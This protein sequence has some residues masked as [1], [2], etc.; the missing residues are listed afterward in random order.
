MLFPL[1]EPPQGRASV[2]VYSTRV[3]GAL[4]ARK[5]EDS[6]MPF[7]V[8]DLVQLPC[9]GAQGS[10]ALGTQVLAAAQAQTLPKSV[11]LKEAQ[12]NCGRALGMS[13]PLTDVPGVPK[14]LGAFDTSLKVLR[15]YVVQ[16]VASV[17]DEEPET[18]AVADA[19]LAPIEAWAM[20]TKR[21]RDTAPVAPAPETGAGGAGTPTD[22]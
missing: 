18:Q 9:L 14:V 4:G 12:A 17:D 6:I 10:R 7:T 21:G 22:K 19:L 15:D 16:V 8:T 13:R 11:V 5:E 2:A 3:A 1:A 20:S